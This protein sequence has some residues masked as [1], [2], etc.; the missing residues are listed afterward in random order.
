MRRSVQQQLRRA[1]PEGVAALTYSAAGRAADVRGSRILEQDAAGT[2]CAFRVPGERVAA[3]SADGRFNVA[4]LLAA[5]T[6]ALRRACP[7]TRWW[8]A[9]RR[10]C[11]RAR[12]HGA[13]ARRVRR[14]WSSTMRIRRTPWPRCSARLRE[15]CPGR[16]MRCSAAAVTAT[17]ASARSWPRR[18]PGMRTFAVVTSDNPRSEDPAQIIADI[19][20]AMRGDYRVERRPRARRSPWPSIRRRAGDCVLI[21]GKG[22]ED[23]QIIGRSPNGLQRQSTWRAAPVEVRRHDGAR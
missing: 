5:L 7:S 18:C 4:N 11:S 22:H 21:A 3:Q 12:A 13:A 23:Y 14:W 15:Q 16:L 10:R 19:E 6:A 8:Q 17:A 20:T 9:V 1:L 2:G